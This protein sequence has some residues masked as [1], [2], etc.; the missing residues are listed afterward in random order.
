MLDYGSPRTGYPI[1]ELREEMLEPAFR[2]I[3]GT[4]PTEAALIASMRH[5]Y[6]YYP[7]ALV[8]GRLAAE[9]MHEEYTWEKAA[10]RFIEILEEHKKDETATPSMRRPASM[11][12][13]F[14]DQNRALAAAYRI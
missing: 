8:K 7:E 6:D 1:A 3:G 12:K 2:G 11:K 9:R 10:K 4:R 14:E 5:V 13:L